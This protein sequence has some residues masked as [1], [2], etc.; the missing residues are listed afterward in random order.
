[1]SADTMIPR[2]GAECHVRGWL[3]LDEGLVWH[4]GRETHY[5]PPS[6]RTTLSRYAGEAIAMPACAVYAYEDR[7]GVA[8]ESRPTS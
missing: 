4:K 3:Q 6:A 5:I 2:Y 7:A 1:M 8:T